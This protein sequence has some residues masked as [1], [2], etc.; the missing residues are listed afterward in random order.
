MKP[1]PLHEPGRIYEPCPTCEDHY[2]RSRAN[3]AKERREHIATAV[4]A[5][6]AAAPEGGEPVVMIAL[7]WADALIAEL[8]K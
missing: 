2:A 7:R 3:A 5:G 4:L 6:L 1:C 8:D